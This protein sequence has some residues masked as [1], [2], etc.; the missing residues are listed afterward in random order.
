MKGFKK[1]AAAVCF[2]SVISLSAMSPAYAKGNAE[3]QLGLISATSTLTKSN[4]ALYKQNNITFKGVLDAKFNLTQ[5]GGT[6]TTPGYV[7][8]NYTL[9]EAASPDKSFK[10]DISITSNAGNTNLAKNGSDF[11][12]RISMYVVPKGDGNYD[13]YVGVAAPGNDTDDPLNDDMGT[14]IKGSGEMNGGSG[15]SSLADNDMTWMHLTMYKNQ[16]GD[17]RLYR[18]KLGVDE[19]VMPNFTAV[20][21][22]EET[23]G[24]ST[25]DDSTEAESAD[26]D[27]AFEGTFSWDDLNTIFNAE[28]NTAMFGDKVQDTEDTDENTNASLLINY[29]APYFEGSSFKTRYFVDKN[30]NLPSAVSGTITNG[31]WKYLADYIEAAANIAKEGGFDSKYIEAEVQKVSFSATYDYADPSISVPEVAKE[32]AQEIGNTDS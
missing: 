19:S 30:T 15:E 7:K 18:Y 32:K 2:A 23:E 28:G 22:L 13:T 8:A 3:A 25:G 21:A 17:D 11:Q 10:L 24:S 12:R 5:D 29:V 27:Y 1:R 4:E 20:P 14:G 6:T 26:N 16:Y 31:K 9:S